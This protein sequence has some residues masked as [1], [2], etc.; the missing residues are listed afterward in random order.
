MQN[1]LMQIFSAF[2]IANALILLVLFPAILSW[3]S[4]DGYLNATLCADSVG[5]N[6][7]DMFPR[8]QRR[9]WFGCGNK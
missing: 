5:C 7:G 6:P 2:R 1:N 9:R 4:S 3:G 8:K